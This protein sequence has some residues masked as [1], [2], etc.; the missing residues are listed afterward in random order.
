VDGVVKRR[1]RGEVLEAAI[2]EAVWQELA[3]NGWA[4]L[5]VDAVASR[6][7]TGKPALYSRWPTKAHLVRAAAVR[8]ATMRRES[9][10]WRGPLRSDLH[11]LLVMDARAMDGPWGEAMR[12]LVAEARQLARTPTDSPS[13]F[14]DTAAI[15]IVVDVITAA[16]KR[17]ELAS[18]PIPIKAI[19]LGFTLVTHHYLVNGV[20]PDDSTI[21]EILDL[22]WL[23]LTAGGETEATPQRPAS[24][25]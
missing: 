14:S 13:Q 1:R 8:V 24:D 4:G 6:A 15:Q 19:N 22:W 16:Q 7:G 10:V 17:G 5:R 20:P 18:D 3:E 25:R 23:S 11:A 2:L 9:A 21:A 12:G